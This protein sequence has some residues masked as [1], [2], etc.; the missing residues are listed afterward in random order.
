[1]GLM[2]ALV[3]AL[4]RPVMAVTHWLC[5]QGMCTR[6][7]A[8]LEACN[9]PQGPAPDTTHCE[10]CS[11]PLWRPLG[12]PLGYTCDCFCGGD[13]TYDMWLDDM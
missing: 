10:L 6:C 11:E 2:E 12:L 9:C 3:G 1:M 8:V 5:D 13:D 4:L 7:Q